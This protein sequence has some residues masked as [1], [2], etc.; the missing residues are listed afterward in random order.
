MTR[1]TLGEARTKI[2]ATVGPACEDELILAELVNH[3]VDIFR[4]NAA[5]GT[6]TDYARVLD[7]IKR[8]RETTGFPVAVL[9]DLAGPKIR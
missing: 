8:V 5:H 2:V 1:N 3:G 6:Q 4:I 7:K 9:L